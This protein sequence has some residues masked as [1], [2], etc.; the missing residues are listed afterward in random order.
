LAAVDSSHVNGAIHICIN[1]FGGSLMIALA[2]AAAIPVVSQT[3][4]ARRMVAPGLAW[5]LQPVERRAAVVAK[6]RPA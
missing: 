1:S 6:T 5:K 4:A 2:V 3:F